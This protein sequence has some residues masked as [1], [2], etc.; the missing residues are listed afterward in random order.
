MSVCWEG[1]CANLIKFISKR[2]LGR[3]CGESAGVWIPDAAAAAALM[4]LLLL[5]VL[6]ALLLARL[7]SL[8]LL[9]LMDPAGEH[10]QRKGSCS[11]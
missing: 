10:A 6:L 11:R 5:L 7:L 9:L 2:R 8:L 1:A 3:G 4:L